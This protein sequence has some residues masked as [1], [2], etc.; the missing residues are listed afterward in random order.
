[1]GLT[2]AELGFLLVIG[3]GLATGVG[4]GVV[5]SSRLIK[6][7]S[8]TM[9]GAAL[10]LSAG[11]ML[12]VSFVEI[13][14]KGFDAFL[15][16]GNSEPNAYLFTT[17]CFFGGILS[18]KLLHELI[19][20]IDPSHMTGHDVDM[21]MVDEIAHRFEEEEKEL[22]RN[23]TVEGEVKSDDG[24]DDNDDH[25]HHGSIGR[26]GTEDPH[27]PAA[28]HAH[29]TSEKAL[30][31]N[32][33]SDALGAVNNDQPQSEADA[34][35]N[36]RQ[37]QAGD[38]EMAELHHT[39]AAK[40][41]I[42]DSAQRRNEFDE[43][44][45][46][47]AEKKKEVDAKLKHMG[48]M[49]ALAIGLH[50]FPEGLATFVA[51]L[52]SPSVGAALAVAIAIHNIPEGLA[53]SV[54]IFF[55]T[56]NRHRAFLWGFMSGVSEIVGAGLGWLVLKDVFSELVFG[57]LFGLVAGMMVAICIYELLPTARRYDP[58]DRFVSNMAVVGMALMAVS[59]V[60]FKY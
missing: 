44:E 60:A 31:E 32:T 56:N 11:V 55:A 21:D 45:S 1:M 57:V 35:G 38:L 50:N 41:L 48:I 47:I 53:V 36:Y 37:L 5:Y 13:F 19:H 9:L 43:R 28:E 49:T 52:S 29:G 30:L 24:D 15:A 7:A 14:V 12:Y 20:W 6:F 22:M 8:K 2:N 23:G 18:M 25:H 46:V 3:A 39:T 51:T 34:A 40:S 17:L 4:A 10:G 33:S 42:F 54:P 16:S 27:R 59:L 58:E 26:N